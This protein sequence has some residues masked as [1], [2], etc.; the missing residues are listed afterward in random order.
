LTGVERHPTFRS[1]PNGTTLP[2]APAGESDTAL[3]WRS[4]LPR[5]VRRLFLQ[6]VVRFF[7]ALRGLGAFTL[8]ALGVVFTKF[9]VARSV[10]RPLLLGQIVRSG[11]ALLPM[12]TFLALALGLVIIGQTMSVLTRVGAQDFLGTVLV[13]VVVRE[14]APLLTAGLVLCRTGGGHG[15]RTGHARALVKSRRSK[16]WN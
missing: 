3:L 10:M 4:P 13:T 6:K 5:A 14:L 12:T 16:R 11:V 1:V 9:N 15:G 7:I 2:N 8:I